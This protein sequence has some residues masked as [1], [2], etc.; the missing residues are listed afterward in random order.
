[1]C[2]PSA[3]LQSFVRRRH[4]IMIDYT[5][6][7]LLI[8]KKVLTEVG[9]TDGRGEPLENVLDYSAIDIVKVSLSVCCLCFIIQHV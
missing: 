8:S 6:N 4:L 3:F 7:P 9:M 5:G 2:R 1:M